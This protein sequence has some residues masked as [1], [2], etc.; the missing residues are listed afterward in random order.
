MTE[1]KPIEKIRAG[2]I[3]ATIWKNDRKEGQDYDTFSITVEKSYKVNEEWKNTSS[4]QLNDLPKVE[5]V[6]QKAYDF[7]LTKQYEKE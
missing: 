1:N 5:L 6:C 7:L 3:T 4:M 2:Q